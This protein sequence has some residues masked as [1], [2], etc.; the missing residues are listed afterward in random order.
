[1]VEQ[2]RQRELLLVAAGELGRRL[3]R[4][5]ATNLEPLDPFRGR[6]A[7][8]PGRQQPAAA[9]RLEAGQRNVVGDAEREREPFV[10]SILAEKA[11]A[12]RPAIA[13]RPVFRERGDLH[14]SAANG[15]ETE[16]RAEQSRPSGAEQPRD[17]EHLTAPQAEAGGA[18]MEVLDLEN[19]LA[20]LTVRPRKEIVDPAADHHG[21]DLVA[22]RV[23]GRVPG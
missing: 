19:R 3:R 2:A 12:L 23:D 9:E 15:L 17:P 18:G 6:G 8:A 11:C 14:A 13:G 1:M 4:S 16:N 21:D 5:R 7:L 10:L 20:V 22:G